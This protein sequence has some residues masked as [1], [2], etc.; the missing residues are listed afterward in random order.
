MVDIL[1]TCHGIDLRSAE[2]PSANRGRSRQRWGLAARLEISY[3]H[4]G[5]RPLPLLGVNR[6][7]HPPGTKKPY[8]SHSSSSFYLSGLGLHG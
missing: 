5:Q 7:A 1:V 3:V 8:S 2:V 6:D 4:H